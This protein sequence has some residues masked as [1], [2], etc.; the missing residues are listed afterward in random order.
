MAELGGTENRQVERARRRAWMLTMRCGEALHLL[1]HE[2]RF[3]LGR[4]YWRSQRRGSLRTLFPSKMAASRSPVGRGEVAVPGSRHWHSRR[5]AGSTAR[6]EG[7]TA[8]MKRQCTGCGIWIS[9][10]CTRRIGAA[11][12]RDRRQLVAMDR[13]DPH[14]QPGVGRGNVA[15]VQRLPA[16]RAGVTGLQAGAFTQ[17]RRDVR[18]L[19]DKIGAGPSPLR[20][21]L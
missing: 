3:G 6:R 17:G 2:A 19:I 13:A 21:A 20:E 1:V 15:R 5:G 18:Q 8:G 9:G 4:A 11:R 12:P 16:H 14:P 7:L 10:S